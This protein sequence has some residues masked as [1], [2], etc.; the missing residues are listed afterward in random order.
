MRIKGAGMVSKLRK[1][2]N[3]HK[4]KEPVVKTKRDKTL[5]L[6]PLSERNVYRYVC[7]NVCVNYKNGKCPKEKI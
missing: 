5:I 6:C 4:I 3:K 1:A 2:L 7:L